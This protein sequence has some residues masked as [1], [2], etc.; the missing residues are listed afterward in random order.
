MAIGLGRPL[1]SYRQQDV[2]EAIAHVNQWG[3]PPGALLI[4][5]AMA[6]ISGIVMFGGT[7]Y[8]IGW[9][10]TQLG[11]LMAGS[12]VGA[13]GGALFGYWGA[14]REWQREREAMVEEALWDIERLR[15]R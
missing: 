11:P 3:S 1:R 7:G 12:L 2:D 4:R 5:R 10:W 6:T 15:H 14:T 13:I 8:G 9:L